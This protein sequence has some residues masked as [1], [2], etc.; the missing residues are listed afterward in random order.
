[1]DSSISQPEIRDFTISDRTV[2]QLVIPE[3]QVTPGDGLT[4]SG[5]KISLSKITINKHN[6]EVA[7]PTEITYVSDIVVDEYGR[8]TQIVKTKAIIA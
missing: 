1:M 4:I 7:S 2:K 3:V 5:G 6:N 8:I